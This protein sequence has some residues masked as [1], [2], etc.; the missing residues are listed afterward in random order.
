LKQQGGDYHE[1]WSTTFTRFDG[2]QITIE[3]GEEYEIS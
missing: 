2:K 3:A 1:D